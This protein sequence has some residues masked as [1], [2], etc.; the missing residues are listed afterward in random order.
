MDT[1]VKI[2]TCE[3]LEF[4]YHI[5]ELDLIFQHNKGHLV[6]EDIIKIN[7]HLHGLDKLTTEL[8]RKYLMKIHH[9]TE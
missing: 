8:K 3:F 1:Q 7:Y 4:Q 2:L 9:N 5:S 6:I